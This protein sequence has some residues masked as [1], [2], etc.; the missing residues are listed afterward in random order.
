MSILNKKD[1]ES[2]ERDLMSLAAV[3]RSA[4]IH[5]VLATQRPSADVVT[6]T[7]KAN[8]DARIAFRVASNT[9]SRVVLDAPGAENLLGRGDMLFRRSSGETLRLQAP[10]M[11]E[12]EM[13]AYL[14]SLGAR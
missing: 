3:S 1:A 2:F 11:G 5:L 9:N 13:Q 7:L 10:F 14:A 8:L 12:E 4:G 6:S